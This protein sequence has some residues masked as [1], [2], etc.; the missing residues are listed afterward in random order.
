[1]RIKRIEV[2]GFK[3]FCDRTVINITSPITS[4]V[5]PN[6]CGKS[7]IVDAIRWCMGEQSA[8]HLRGKAMDDV[9]FA[10]SESRGPASMAEVSLTFEDVGFSQEALQM[11]LDRVVDDED[12]DPSDLARARAGESAPTDSTIQAESAPAASSEA[13][14]VEGD[15]P[16]DEMVALAGDGQ[17]EAIEG[18]T[19]LGDVADPA[20]AAAAIAAAPPAAAP[21]DQHEPA[22]LVAG[23]EAVADMAAEAGASAVAGMAAEAGEGELTRSASE[24]VQEFLEDKPPA[25][26]FAEYSEVT[27]TRRLFRDGTSQYLINRVPCRLRDVTDFFLGTG[28]G[29]K[30]Y[31]I[32]EQGRVGMIVSAR[33][34][35]RRAIIEEAAGITKFKT[36]KRAAERKL[37]QTRHNLVRVS[38]IVSE[39]GK[40]MGSL[41]RQAQKAERYRR[42]KTDIRDIE[43]WKAAHKFL[44]LRAE[45]K[46]LAQTLTEC[47]ETLAT[48]RAEYETKDAQVVTERGELATEERRLSSLQETIYEQENRIRLSESK[49][50]FQTRE[51]TEI[52][53]RVAAARGEILGLEARREEGATQLE[54]QQAEPRGHEPPGR[55]R[56]ERGR[57]PR[58][59]RGRGPADARQRAV[60][61]RRGAQPAV[62]G[63]LG[64]G[65]RREPQGGAGPAPRGDPSPPG[66]RPVRHRG[67]QRARRQAR[68]GEPRLR[69]SARRP[70][71]DPPR[72][73]LAVRGPGSPAP[74]PGRER[75]ALRGPGGDAAHRGSIVAARACSRWS[76]SRRSTRASPAAPAR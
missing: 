12:L 37:E 53:Q 33:P 66:A 68:H 7:N 64:F 55:D 76:R 22:P 49:V 70:A 6:G 73:R 21:G 57:R 5:G 38:D 30:A 11:A 19:E 41:R 72:S 26:N 13:A 42:Y 32:I 62:P 27:I 15:L 28:V 69:A 9:I 58:D 54:T 16:T 1:M 60:A 44:E 23:A 39:L 8:R 4:V 74:H 2:I 43:L 36:K 10:G 24:D 18:Q 29:T 14:P 35:D 51:A 20:V 25:F 48:V 46:L 50:A 31:S 52:D 56:G 67:G 3:S 63:A 71:P 61:A 75:A 65:A 45:E 40:R 59:G 17:P 47:R 34:Q